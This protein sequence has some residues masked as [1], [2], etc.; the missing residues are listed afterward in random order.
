MEYLRHYGPGR[1]YRRRA[2]RHEDRRCARQDAVATRTDRFAVSGWRR[3]VQKRANST[4]VNTRAKSR[5]RRAESNEV[6]L[7][8][9][10]CSQ[11]FSRQSSTFTGTGFDGITSGGDA[12]SPE[13][14]EPV[15]SEEVGFAFGST[16]F[17]CP[18]EK[19]RVNS[20]V[21]VWAVV[22][23]DAFVVNTDSG[24]PFASS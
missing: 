14:S 5:E 21:S 4:A 7:L 18:V 9:A 10:L 1:S 24:N 15:G 12:T 22:V 13:L 2:E 11:L 19:I 17:S 8:S 3:E 20:C 6:S 23:V 16:A